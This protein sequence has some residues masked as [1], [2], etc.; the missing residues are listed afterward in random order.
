MYSYCYMMSIPTL[1]K[2]ILCWYI[3]K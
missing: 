3:F 2:K 1:T